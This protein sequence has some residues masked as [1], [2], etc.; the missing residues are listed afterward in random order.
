MSQTGDLDQV[1][2]RRGSFSFTF[3]I[4]ARFICEDSSPGRESRQQDVMWLS[5]ARGVMAFSVQN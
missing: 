2:Q 4:Q 1:L 3:K 5:K